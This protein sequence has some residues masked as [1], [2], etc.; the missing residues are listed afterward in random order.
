MTESIERGWHSERTAYAYE[1]YAQ[2]HSMYKVTARDLVATAEIGPGM[3]V[4]DVACGTG[5]VI[6]AILE[7]LDET[8]SVIG[9]DMSREMLAVAGEKIQAANVAFVQ[10]PA[11]RLNEGIEATADVAVCNSAFWQIRMSEA[12][13]ALGI[14]LKANGR[15]VFNLPHGFFQFTVEDAPV[16]SSPSLYQLM[17]DIATHEYGFTPPERLQQRRPL[18]F[19]LVK[20]VI[21]KSGFF[22]VSHQT[23]TY[24]K[25]IEETLAF[26]RI[27]IMLESRLPRLSEAARIAILE[28]AW[29]QYE[30]TSATLA[31]TWTYFVTENRT[32]AA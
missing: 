17:L 30:K 2:A 16:S 24:Q 12:L 20:S 10:S 9:V 15:F 1:E 5:I 26:L 23:I 31:D 11:E 28:K 27:P 19:A 14:V 18:D 32:N 8:G 3:T 4:L 6:E 22:L 29:A 13:T 7:R 21:E 25:P